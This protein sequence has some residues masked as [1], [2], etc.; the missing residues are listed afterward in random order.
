MN[1]IYLK[2]RKN[3]I[4]SYWI[5]DILDD[6]K[7]GKIKIENDNVIFSV[8]K[9]YKKNNV[10]TE[11]RLSINY[12]KLTWLDFWA[13]FIKDINKDLV[14]IENYNFPIFAEACQLKQ[15]EN[16]MFN[17][18]TYLHPAARKAW[19]KMQKTATKD[20]IDLQIIS[21]FRSLNYQKQLIENKL[22]KGIPIDEILKVNT[23]PGYSEHHTGCAIDI[24]SKNSAILEENFDQ[25]DAFNWLLE[26]AHKFGFTLSYP[27]GNSTGI[28]Y[29]PWHWC[30]R[31][32]EHS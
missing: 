20:N 31:I 14:D 3:K 29:E 9:K 6:K 24:G 16:D 22:A 19:L 28:F 12:F 11:A 13:G 5:K 4:N 8:K 10:G 18:T 21:A 27:K 32:T 1:R 26:N 17:R 15:C 2:P 30:Y 25:S 23:L 7:L